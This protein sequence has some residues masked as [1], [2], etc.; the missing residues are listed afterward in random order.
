[1]E[2]SI[3]LEARARMLADPQWGSQ[4]EWSETVGR[5]ASADRMAREL[6][7][8]IA[9]SG[10]KAKVAAGIFRRVMSALEG[11]YDPSTVFGH[12]GK[13]AAMSSIWRDRAALFAELAA[14]PDDQVIEWCGRRPWIGDITKYHAAK[15]FGVD[16]GKPDR[17]M[18]RVAALTGEPVAALCSRLAKATGDRVATVD[19]VVWWAMSFKTLLIREG[20]LEFSNDHYE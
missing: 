10:M 5:P 11:G 16:V 15:N 2:V 14:L 6:I 13:V 3:Y 12:A 19:L 18:E 8:V 20:K 1:M 7:F 4:L 9:N 17:W